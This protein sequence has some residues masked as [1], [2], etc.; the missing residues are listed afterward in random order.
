MKIVA[1][2]LVILLTVPFALVAWTQG[3]RPPATDE[4]F[5][6]AQEAAI[7]VSG[8]ALALPGIVI[9]CTQAEQLEFY[10]IAVP[11][12]ITAMVAAFVMLYR[13]PWSSL[14]GT[15]GFIMAG[16]GLAFALNLQRYNEQN[17]WVLANL[18]QHARNFT[19]YTA[20][21]A[22]TVAAIINVAVV[23]YFTE[24]VSMVMFC[25]AAP[26]SIWLYYKGQQRQALCIGAFLVVWIAVLG[27]F[28]LRAV[29][30]YLVYNQIIPLLAALL[31]AD[32]LLSL[33]SA[34]FRKWLTPILAGGCVVLLI[35]EMR[36]ALGPD[37]RRIQSHERICLQA[38]DLSRLPSS[39]FAH[40]C[41]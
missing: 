36:T 27:F 3:N 37:V 4:E 20:F 1:L 17:I 31:A 10:Q 11:S 14:F 19:E 21:D 7:L 16:S 35:F 28:S 2:P 15:L 41:S 9:L 24:T 13:R 25:F 6:P 26:T 30:Y 33:S 8:C 40:Y 18:T 5:S 12:V 29:P 22:E 23:E 39:S 38:M 34:R 32:G